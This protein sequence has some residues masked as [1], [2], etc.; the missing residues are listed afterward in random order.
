MFEIIELLSLKISCS[1]ERKT[2]ELRRKE[3]EGKESCVIRTEVGN[4]PT[5]NAGFATPSF[6][7][8]RQRDAGANFAEF[9]T[10]S[11]IIPV[12]VTEVT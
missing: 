4:F 8:T 1:R 5:G 12:H 3:T 9:R 10:V 6:V 2:R 11:P 7:W